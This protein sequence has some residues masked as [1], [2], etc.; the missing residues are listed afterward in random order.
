MTAL[1]NNNIELEGF[2]HINT[3]QLI[4]WGIKDANNISKL[5]A[6]KQRFIVH[7]EVGDNEASTGNCDYFLVGEDLAEPIK[8]WD[9][10]G[11]IIGRKH[12]T[13][14]ED[15]NVAKEQVEIQVNDG[16]LWAKLVRYII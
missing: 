16:K 1:I 15:I 7:D 9:N 12:L 10:F 8:L 11:N 4:E 2:E 3:Q 5:L 14:V 13:R 6:A